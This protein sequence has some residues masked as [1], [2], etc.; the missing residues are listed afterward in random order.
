[1]AD[2]RWFLLGTPRAEYRGQPCHLER[3]KAV[4]LATY[5]LLNPKAHSREKL[6][7]LLW[8]RLGPDEARAALRATLPALTRLA[9]GPWLNVDRQSVGVDEGL[10][11][12]DAGR[13]GELLEAL[14]QHDHPPEA[15]CPA[16]LQ[17]MEEA[18]GIYRGHLLE[19]F[20][21]DDAPEFNHW[22]SL[23]REWLSQSQAKLLRALSLY[24]APLERE[25]SLRY[26]RRWV[27]H[28]PLHE[29]AHRLLMRALYENG[30]RAEALQQYQA[31]AR[32][33]EAG[34]A[35][36]PEE[37]TTRLYQSM[38]SREEIPATPSGLVA[39]TPPLP[40]LL[41]GREG[42]LHNLRQRLGAGGERRALTVVEG[43]PGVGKST[44]SA[45]LAHDPAIAGDFPDGV[46]W[47][48]LGQS[49][50]KLA[51]LLLWADALR[52]TTP[53]NPTP[54][55]LSRQIGAALRGRRMLLIVDDVWRPGDAAPFLV[56]G[57]HCATV[58]TT[59][60][61]PV[62]LALAP[63]ARDLYRLSPLEPDD[64]LRLLE[65]VSPQTVQQ[66]PE[67]S[68]QLVSDLGGLPL[69]L[70]V[71]GRLLETEARLGGDTAQLLDELRQGAG[72]LEA[73]A[74][75]DRLDGLEG[76]PQTLP[77]VA[78]LLRQ[79]TDG[80]EA[81]DR[82]RFA[83]LSLFMPK[84]GS[85]DLEALAALWETPDPKPTVRRLLGRGLLEPTGGGR[86]QIH[87]LLTLH[88][89][90]LLEPGEAEAARR[91]YKGHYLGLLGRQHRAL[92]GPGQQEAIAAIGRE[93]EPV[94]RAWL[95]AVEDGDGELLEATT[96]TLS[97]YMTH[98]GRLTLGAELYAPAAARAWA[99]PLTQA[100]LTGAY[101][102]VQI[103]LG[104]PA[105]GEAR[106]HEELERFQQHRATGAVPVVL[107]ACLGSWY[108]ATGRPDRAEALF[109][110]SLQALREGPDDDS[111]WA[112]VQLEGFRAG[113]ERSRGQPQAA[114]GRLEEALALAGRVGD[115]VQTSWLRSVKAETLLQQ[116]RAEEA[117]AL[118][119]A[120]WRYFRTVDNRW[121]AV[122]ALKSLGLLAESRGQA[123]AALDYLEEALESV[124]QVGDH[125]LKLE[126]AEH[127]ARLKD[128]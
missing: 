118:I 66:H 123:E 49:P 87:A 53:P 8:P 10:A 54:A 19:G 16:C 79:S 1:M 84:P 15:P 106:M 90:T 88:A 34:L 82:R 125:A 27:E 64:G 43:W 94:S 71:A 30:Q 116:G 128:Q 22:L 35:T 7:E 117:E 78:A 63:A 20:G 28:E 75:L 62:A 69:A 32:L 25:T 89:R 37:E 73:E 31:F 21:L 6:T 92:L 104:Q 83:L 48:T 110:Q 96:F 76:G 40:P 2:L 97:A 113:L 112:R 68:R 114:L 60:S 3:R 36:P 65:V 11:W 58:L 55:L 57:P 108:A 67:A 29:P 85:F 80:L 45:T 77:T 51:E 52:L 81:A 12:S 109:A 38:R 95:W 115:G 127:I 61:D 119:R 72:L 5:L 44:L 18:V 24:F 59:R 23:Q 120:N 105:E 9:P 17:T 46:L 42:D 101:G 41:V 86:F 74:P 100:H 91:R 102:W 121:G 4:A 56:G 26:L 107:A 39:L 126:I 111:D 93:L 99:S 103:L 13:F 122:T 98:T 14:R 70:R 47:A 124:G 33:L 50:N